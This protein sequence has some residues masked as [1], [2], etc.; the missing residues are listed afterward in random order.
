MLAAMDDGTQTALE[1]AFEL[2]RSGKF[3]TT[4][5]IRQA[6]KDEGFST[7][8]ITGPT[9]NRQLRKAINE[10]KAFDADRT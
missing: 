2:A 4:G 9:L 10:G 5:E 6:L 3:Q 7:D 1:R 8:Q